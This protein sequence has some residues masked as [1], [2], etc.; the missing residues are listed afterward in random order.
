MPSLKLGDVMVML[1]TGTASL[2]TL[3]KECDVHFPTAMMDLEA[4]VHQYKAVIARD[5]RLLNVGNSMRIEEE[6]VGACMRQ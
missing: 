5:Q 3:A 1:K 4:S 2:S 6:M